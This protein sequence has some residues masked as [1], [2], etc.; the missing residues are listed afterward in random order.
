M[1]ITV[2]ELI[3]PIT[4]TEGAKKAAYGLSN[5]EIIISPANFSTDGST[6]GDFL[7]YDSEQSALWQP[8]PFRRSIYD[9]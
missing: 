7:E 4:L 1:K 8:T 6:Y 3:E 2:Q 9:H 5:Q